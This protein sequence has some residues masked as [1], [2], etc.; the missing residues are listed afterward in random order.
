M[1]QSS[2]GRKS[3]INPVRISILEREDKSLTRNDQ[4]RTQVIKPK[5]LVNDASH[6]PRLRFR[7]S[8]SD[9]AISLG[10]KSHLKMT[11]KTSIH[12]TPATPVT[13]VRA[14]TMLNLPSSSK[15]H[16]SGRRSPS[17]DRGSTVGAKSHRKDTRPLTD[18]TYQMT[19]LN[20]IENY[21][22]L[23]QAASMLNNNGS[24]KP[25]TL[26][27]FVEA[28]NFL[29]KFCDVKQ[30]LTMTNYVE[31]LP[32][33]AK[34]LHYPGVMTKSWLK[35]AN[36]MHSWPYVLGWIGW[37][38]E[39]CQVKQLACDKYQLETIPF[40]GTEQEA[41]NSK[42]E[43]LVLLECYKAWNE[44]KHEEE[45]ELFERYLQNILIEQGIT[46][47]HKAQAS[48]EL[49]EETLKSEAMDEELKK[50]DEEID[51]L[52][53]ELSSW[54]A[55]EVKLSNDVKTKEDYIEKTSTEANQLNKE[56]NTLNEQIRLKNIRC[57]EL[58]STLKN[59]PMSKAEKENIIKKC[60]EIQ[61]FIH[62]F[63]E[64]L[65][66]YQKEMYTLDIKLASIINNINKAVL[67][68]NKELFMCI[69]NTIAHSDVSFDKL[70]LPEKGLLDPVIIN[71][72][73]EKAD[74]T[75][76]YK[77]LLIKQ[78]NET[79]SVIRSNTIK[80]EKL[81]E[82]I[83]NLPDE[84]KLQEE[85]SVINKMKADA[86][87]DK[88][89]LIKEI[90]IFKNEIKEIEDMISD[91]RAVDKEIEEGKEKLEAAA[92]RKTF[93]EENAKR[94]FEKKLYQ[95][96]DDHRNELYKLLKKNQK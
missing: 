3:S 28:S 25:I 35:T 87:Q 23:N 6:I 68:Y 63:E 9:Q 89:K 81:Q 33:C 17:A 47:E 58:I 59:Q 92:K 44:E 12:P 67:V 32:K 52:R 61:N 70:K 78:W 5:I 55:K 34:K 11:G 82:D 40:I 96:L 51:K 22:H 1:H 43:F 93:L 84:K 49:E 2:A 46:K 71:I 72:L 60:T 75:K 77:E 31:E 64:H 90:E 36:A 45:A 56:C 76:F 66:D 48:E 50:L 62:I 13:P 74:L 10:R 54:Q 83:N 42:M 29:L 41:Q 14:N 65:K 15:L 27:M 80:L 79:E 21:L 38:V 94:F 8:S 91:L 24:L 7:S 86:K 19:L 30:D 69:D 88:E 85:K 26:K 37:M 39:A 73:E 4:R 95:M 16:A 57:E 53:A 20:K 18:K